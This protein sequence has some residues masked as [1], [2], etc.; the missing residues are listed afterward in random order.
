MEYVQCLAQDLGGGTRSLFPDPKDPYICALVRLQSDHVSRTL[1]PA[2][3]R[4]LQAQDPSAQIEGGK[5]FYEAIEHLV[6]LLEKT[7]RECERGNG[8]YKA[9]GLWREGGELGWTD[10]MVGPWL[11]RAGNVLKHYRGFSLPSGEKFNAWLQRLLEHP[12]FKGTCSDEELYI[13][14]YERYAFNRPG[15]SQV[16]N[17]I[18]SGRGLP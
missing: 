5:E 10:V 14:S 13:D 11:F 1:V 18:N 7:E 4:Y 8:D 9:V 17:A 12:A 6:K 16:A 15:T 2:F 3:Y